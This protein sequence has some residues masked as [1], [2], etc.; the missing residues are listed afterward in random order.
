MSAV[1]VQL[2]I[3]ILLLLVVPSIVGGLCVDS[4]N[5]SK[6]LIFRWVS[7]QFLL[8][9]GFQILYVPLL[10]MEQNLSCLVNVFSGYMAILT[11]LAVILETRRWKKKEW[12]KKRP[13]EGILLWVVFAILLAFQLVQAVRLAF[14]DADDA[15]YVSVASLAESSDT[16]FQIYPYARGATPLDR[17]HALASFSI[18]IAFL[19][20]LSGMRTV[21][22]A[23][24]VLPVVLIAMA[25]GIY[26]LCSV[27]LFPQHSD[28]RAFF[29]VFTAILV[30]FG[31]YSVYTSE[32]FLI[33]RSRQGKA[34]LGSIV[35]PFLLYLL[36]ELLRKLQNSEKIPGLLYLLLGAVAAAGCMCSTMGTFL[37]CV[38]MG[39]CGLLGAICLKRPKVVLPLLLC[40][41]PCIAYGLLYIILE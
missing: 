25:Y 22:V 32:T 17:R 41:L 15:Y 33:G 24:V 30:L 9:A 14:N 31:N 1:A 12:E 29:L 37:I 5:H 4:H 6:G 36:S 11:L 20:R 23:Q 38:P 19:A 16:M 27:L 3:L 13:S 35:I 39:V 34:T 7:G 2:L 28:K 10:L 40:C 26:Y 18:W 21:A 8:W